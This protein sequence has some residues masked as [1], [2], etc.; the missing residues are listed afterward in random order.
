MNRDRPHKRPAGKKR[1]RGSR[2]ST[3][4]SRRSGSAR[5]V[6]ARALV[7][8]ERSSVFISRALE[9]HLSTGQVS[10]ADRRLATE[11]A[12]GVVRRKATLDAVIRPNVNRPQDNVEQELWT[13]MR[14]GTYQL[15]F[16][17]SIPTRAAVHE[18]VELAAAFG[19]PRWKGFLNAILRSV[20]RTLLDECVDE[21]AADAIPIAQGNFRRCASAICPDAA[22]DECGYFAAAFSFPEWLSARW[23]DRFDFAELCR[24][25]FWYDR[26]AP[27]HLRTNRLKTTRAV[28]IAALAE[29]GTS[30]TEG[31]CQESVRLEGTARVDRL[32]GFAE[33]WF[34]VQDESA[35]YAA[36]LLAPQPGQC[37]LDLCAAPGSKTTHL[38]ELMQNQGRIVATDVQQDKLDKIGQNATRL[39]LEIIEPCLIDRDG[40]DI[41]PGL[42]DAILVDAP[43]SN[44][45]VIGKR[46][47]VRWRLQPKDVA[48]LVTLQRR[49]LTA[50]AER[51]AP[52]GRLVYSTCSIEP[53]ENAQNVRWL[54]ADQ[55]GLELL[56]EREHVPGSP[57]DGGYQALF[58]KGTVT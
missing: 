5:E 33:G 15:V 26:P 38:A 57:A 23:A 11:L 44:T 6:A 31:D 30:A 56:T 13:L 18:T 22:S 3:A 25:G 8:Y 55:P 48:E 53:E 47:D 21:P 49:L 45:G 10:D 52:G 42:F 46:P 51:L 50:A 32:P 54:L 12:L 41:P 29:A 17:N 24:M 2:T 39:E 58:R 19:Q 35:M 14:L 7:D 4:S 9:E 16:M 20:S 28:F 40:T 37:V 1:N 27:V 34:S 43:C 36:T